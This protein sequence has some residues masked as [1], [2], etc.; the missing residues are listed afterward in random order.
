[1]SGRTIGWLLDE[2]DRE[3]L[4]ERIPP[5]FSRTIAHHVTLKSGAAPEEDAPAAHQAAV[6]GV[7]GDGAGV[8][9]VIVQLN[10][11]TERPDGGTYHIT[12][13]LAPGRKAIESNDVLATHDWTPFGPSPIR[14]Q[15]ASF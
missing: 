12:W 2:R 14:L 1:M 4:L 15:P 9:A 6:V 7:A 3:S 13:S 8:Q 10:G 11:T 5:A